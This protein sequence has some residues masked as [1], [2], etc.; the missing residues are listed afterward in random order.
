MPLAKHGDIEEHDCWRD[1]AYD[2]D[3]SV[4]YILLAT[5]CYPKPN[6]VGKSYG[7]VGNTLLVSDT[8]N[9]HRP[10]SI[11][12]L[13]GAAFYPTIELIQNPKLIDLHCAPSDLDWRLGLPLRCE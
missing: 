1:G 3:S 4:L 13:R 7:R 11:P 12:K 9:N 6:I 10:R 2:A 5:C 8:K